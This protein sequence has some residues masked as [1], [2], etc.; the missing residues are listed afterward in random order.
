MLDP[1]K[2]RIDYGEQLNPPDG[3]QLVKAIGTTYS[4]DLEALMLLPVALFYSQKIET[5]SEDLRCDII[6]AITKFSSK[7]TIF[8]HKGQLKVPR[9]YHKLMAHLEDGI[10]EVTMPDYLSSFHPKIWVAR[11]ECKG[12]PIIYRLLVTSRNL[13]FSRD[14]DVA[15]STD[16]QVTKK[17]NPKVEPL[18]HFIQFLNNFK[19]NTIRG[20][21][22]ED[23]KK[24]EF[25]LPPKFDSLN[26]VPI[27]IKNPNNGK[28][29]NN[30][31]TKE[32]NQY[33]DLLIVSPFVDEKTLKRLGSLTKNQ[34]FLL[35]RKEEL[36]FLSQ[37][38]LRNFNCWMF[39]KYIEE[40]EQLPQLSEK[41]ATPV[42]QSLHAKLFIANKNKSP[43]WYL[44]S[45][46]CSDPAQERN[47]EFMVELKGS[48]SA[49]LRLNDVLTVLTESKQSEGQ[50]LFE[51]YPLRE[52]NK[53]DEQK[54]LDLDIRKIKYNLINMS[55]KGK[56]RLIEGGTTYNLII[57]I[58]ATKLILPPGFLVKTK[59]LP[60][61][62]LATVKIKPG[63]INK[64]KDFKGYSKID[65][66]PYLI[67]EIWKEGE[68][69][70]E[71]L[72]PMEI[73]L[74]KDRVSAIFRSI[75]NSREKF[76]KYLNFLLTEEEAF[77][78][79]GKDINNG[80][81]PPNGN[82]YSSWMVS[83]TQVYEK[84]LIAASR[85]PDRLKSINKLITRLKKESEGEESIVTDEFEKFWTKFQSFISSKRKP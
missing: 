32:D 84:L 55:V 25:D 63:A 74:P 10:E 71:F 66:S 69:I 28:T 20:P 73:R 81:W 64:I 36:D 24:V 37:D 29:Y 53:I 48:N 2:N 42:Y 34:T 30:P 50:A 11:Y 1:R 78:L 70:T 76:I 62:K 47:I 17:E 35:S 38:V 27:G 72:M 39:S 22:L 56:A 16:G 7:I 26:F 65:L 23:L 15:F 13:T 54:K 3:Y 52:I 60:E 40:A 75:I 85:Y 61:Q 12:N 57:N 68:V 58:D 9:E 31:I 51:P 8:Y 49:G 79:E 33:D 46:N 41:E 6:D 82:G 83:G 5:N 67:F 80:G 21:F 44:G 19:Q 4:L 45:A 14:W 18:V 59:P 43:Y 77:P